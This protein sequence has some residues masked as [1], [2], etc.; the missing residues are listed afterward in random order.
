MSCNKFQKKQT[1][2]F[3]SKPVPRWIKRMLSS[4]NVC[5]D[6][7]PQILDMVMSFL[8]QSLVSTLQSDRSGLAASTALSQFSLTLPLPCGTPIS[9]EDQVLNIVTQIKLIRVNLAEAKST[10]PSTHCTTENSFSFFTCSVV[11]TEHSCGIPE[12]R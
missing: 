9:Q 12:Q 10:P 5:Y 1:S 7:I 3:C 4:H 11:S 6:S 2:E 8:F